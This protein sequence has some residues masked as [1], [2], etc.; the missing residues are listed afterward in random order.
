MTADPSHLHSSQV[1][2]LFKSTTTINRYHI[3]VMANILGI[4]CRI[5]VSWGGVL[6]WYVL[7]S[8]WRRLAVHPLS[9]NPPRPRW[10]ICSNI[11]IY[12]NANSITYICARFILMGQ[13]FQK[14]LKSAPTVGN[15]LIVKQNNC[16]LRTIATIVSWIGNGKFLLWQNEYNFAWWRHL[17]CSRQISD[18]LLTSLSSLVAKTIF[19]ELLLFFRTW[20]IPLG[21]S[22]LNDKMSPSSSLPYNVA[23]SK[24][25]IYIILNSDLYSACVI[26]RLLPPAYA[27]GNVLVMPVCLFGF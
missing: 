24:T 20:M 26:Y 11:S 3:C 1:R 18:N 15:T 10:S 2:C 21:S 16:I 9:G 7:S 5:M 13:K 17:Q 23:I 25:E 19:A 4:I 12:F 6:I 27:V 14:L 22:T 8:I